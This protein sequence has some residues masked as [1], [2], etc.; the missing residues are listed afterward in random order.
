MRTTHSGVK[1]C[2]MNLSRVNAALDAVAAHAAT[3]RVSHAPP[4]L[5]CGMTGFYA[6]LIVAIAGGLI[7]G[8]SVALIGVLA[9]VSAASFYPYVFVRRWVI[10]RE[11]MVRLDQVW[12]AEA[13]ATVALGKAI[14]GVRSGP[15]TASVLRSNALFINADTSGPS[16]AFSLTSPASCWNR[17]I[18]RRW[19]GR[20]VRHH[21]HRRCQ[22]FGAPNDRMQRRAHR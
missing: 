13:C 21:R 19:R 15:R 22:R 9:V 3:A 18:G 16:L 14:V 1:R 5:A 17:N 20:S 7:R 6:A 4:F 12:I 11:Q 2:V 8:L 10:G